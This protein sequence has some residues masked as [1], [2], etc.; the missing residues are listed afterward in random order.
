MTLV[1]AARGLG[2]SRELDRRA[3]LYNA[4][5][6]D[7]RAVRASL[8]ERL[9]REW[10]RVTEDVPYWRRLVTRGELPRSFES[11]EAFAAAVPPTTR[12]LVHDHGRELASASRPGELVRR[13]GGSTSQPV[14]LPAWRSE[15]AAAAADN[16]I[17]RAWYG[18]GPGSRLF[19][20]WGHSHLHG[21]GLRG[22]LAG[23]G[24]RARDRALGY[25]RFS[26]YDLRPEAMRRAA[27]SLVAHRPHYVIGYSAALDAFARANL[28]RQAR[29][30]ALGLRVVIATSEAFP[31]ADSAALLERLLA[32]PVAMEYGAVE[33]GVIAHT[34]PSGGYR[35]YWESQLLDAERLAPGE[36]HRLRVTSLAPR[37][38]PLVRYEIGDEV[39]LEPTAPDRVVGLAR[40]ARVVG[41]ANDWVEL[42]DGARIHSETFSHAA[43][44]CAEIR[45]FQIV[46]GGAGLALRYVADAALS[47]QAERELRRRLGCVH[48]ALES[49]R[50]ERVE[51]LEQTVAGKTRMV[52]S[53]PS[54]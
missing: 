46:R 49:L 40:F 8:L 36:P 34:H 2:F 31:S 5:A 11:L 9:D 6:I 14:Q 37:C 41:R 15:I 29:L 42:P 18:V 39:E 25:E 44:E 12:A 4:A 22:R 35:A 50:L 30:S 23:L 33:T 32:A 1:G 16:W 47:A 19:M 45:G 21:E 53:E 7:E 20:L 43:R 51:R 3:A 48:A 26:A 10:R 52:V 38:F 54:P 27:D 13:T 17:G 28:D 24:R